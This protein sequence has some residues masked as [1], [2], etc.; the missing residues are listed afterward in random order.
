[1]KIKLQWVAGTAMGLALCAG[2]AMATGT[3]SISPQSG[4]Q[5]IIDDLG[6]NV[7]PAGLPLGLTGY[8]SLGSTGT[9][10][11][12]LLTPGTYDFTYLG[13]GDAVDHDTFTVSGPGGFTF[14]NKSTAV[15]TTFQFTISSAG[16][17]GFLYSN[18]TGG[19]SIADSGAASLGISYGLFMQGSTGCTG[20]SPLCPGGTPLTGPGT[21]AYIGLADLPSPTDHDFQDLGVRVDAVPEPVTW[22]MMLL[23]FGGVGAVLRGQRR[24][25]AP[26]LA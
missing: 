12:L 16:D 25:Q 26:S 7:P 8:S 13:S 4:G 15:G 11:N 14:D 23:G 24:R 22:A 21:S 6:G 19:T 2:S 18:L 10:P 1:M 17:L 20:V 9:A 5:E 3:I